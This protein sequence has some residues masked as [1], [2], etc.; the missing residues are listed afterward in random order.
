MALE[1]ILHQANAYP[2]HLMAKGEDIIKEAALSS[3][4]E[5]LPAPTF[6]SEDI[7]PQIKLSHPSKLL[8]EDAD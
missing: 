2:A 7:L 1:E 5:K 8:A 6:L 4:D 3:F